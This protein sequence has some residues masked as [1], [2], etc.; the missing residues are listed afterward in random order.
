MPSG[1]CRPSFVASSSAACE[2]ETHGALLAEPL[3]YSKLRNG[4][5]ALPI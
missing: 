5:V 3:A 1:R 4:S 2:V